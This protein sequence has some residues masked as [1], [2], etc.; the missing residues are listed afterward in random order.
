[1]NEFGGVFPDTLEGMESLPGIGRSTAGAILSISMSQ[2][3]PIL[4]GNVKRGLARYFGIR[5]YPGEAKIEARMWQ[6]ADACTPAQD[7]ASYTQAIM[8]LGATVCVRSRPLCNACPVEKHCI[9]RIKGLQSE[10]P[11]RK[12]RKARPQRDAFALL[13]IRRDGAVLLEKRPETGLWGGL[14]AFP[15]F[16]E[17]SLAS[18]WLVERFGSVSEAQ[19]EIYH[20]A[21]T[22][23]DLALHPV[24]ARIDAVAA[25]VADGDRHQWYD[26]TRPSK[27]GLT[28][29]VVDLI[30]QLVLPAPVVRQHSL[31]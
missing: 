21:F 29:P 17:R 22:H 31:L 28:K 18:Q 1:M 27:I 11:T 4:D 12:I 20:H 14:W 19:G 16:D 10:L 24:I 13:V 5:G 7:V 6:L 30:R 9:A 23:F 8:D 15:Q 26:A 2:R 25:M 3:H